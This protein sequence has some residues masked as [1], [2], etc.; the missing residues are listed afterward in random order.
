MVPHLVYKAVGT[1]SW[2]GARPVPLSA[3]AV[4]YV[5]RAGSG[6]T[7]SCGP[8]EEAAGDS[9]AQGGAGAG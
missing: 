4:A 9:P 1:R 3:V 2:N 8:V 7:L 6:P 5:V